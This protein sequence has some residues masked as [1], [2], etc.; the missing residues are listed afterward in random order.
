MYELISTWAGSEES[1]RDNQVDKTLGKCMER[2]RRLG[3]FRLD[4]QSGNPFEIRV[5]CCNS[6]GL[7]PSSNQ[8]HRT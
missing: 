4:S 1:G 2:E 6:A 3:T 7:L 8:G 5:R